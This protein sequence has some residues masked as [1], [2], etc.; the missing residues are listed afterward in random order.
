[1][2]LEALLLWY[3]LRSLV[4]L[5][6][7]ESVPALS[8]VLIDSGQKAIIKIQGMGESQKG[9]LLTLS[10]QHRVNVLRRHVWR[11]P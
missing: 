8:H 6:T 4:R 7:L 2:R 9:Q 1:M 11:D 5:V 10:A 3:G